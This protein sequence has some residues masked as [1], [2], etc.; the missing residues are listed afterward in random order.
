LAVSAFYAVGNV[1]LHGWILDVGSIFLP[2]P[3][4]TLSL[5]FWGLLGGIA[6]ASFAVALV[7]FARREGGPRGLAWLG[8]GGDPLWLGAGVALALA[9]PLL[10]RR[11]VL[12]GAPLSDDETAYRFMAQLLASGRIRVLS[13]PMKTFFDNQFM[14][15]DGH[16][17][18]Q[19]FLGWPALLAPGVWLRVPGAMNALYSALTVPALFLSLRRLSGSRWARLGLLLFLSAPMLQI[20]AATELSHTSCLFALAW[21]AWLTLR[22][23]DSEAPVWS[24]AGVALAFSAAFFNRP[25]AALGVGGPLL[26][27]WALGAFRLPAQRRRAALLAFA[28]PA[29]AMAALFLAANRIQTGSA[30]KVAYQRALE[31]AHETGTRFTTRGRAQGVISTDMVYRGAGYPL[32]NLAIALLR[33]NVEFLG[34]SGAWLIACC[35]GGRRWARLAWAC[36]ACFFAV[37]LLLYSTGIDTFGPLHYFETALPL[38]VLIV[39]AVE[40]VSRWLLDCEA[41]PARVPA[42]S[43][44]YPVALVLG[45]VFSALLGYW[46]VRLALLSRLAENINMPRD[47]AIAAHLD[48]A[49][50]FVHRPYA[51]PCR[52]WPAQH[53][54][55]FRP[56]NDPDLRNP[57][58]WVN[59]LTVEEDRQLMSTLPG[60]KGYLL[61]WRPDCRVRF[62]PLE[63]IPPGVEPF[64]ETPAAPEPS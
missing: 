56:N 19:Y 1:H 59:H 62:A 63:E 13:P 38:L 20:A 5:L 24:H 53:F 17:Y 55:F 34:W 3:V 16:F 6:A 4:V 25:T 7:G 28:A 9:I 45:L 14:I 22:S 64:A 51:P 40:R 37:H 35:A 57:V 36:L 50:V 41:A 26:V 48:Q 61:L 32:A 33:L 39:L 46:P 15:N 43:S 42:G 60:R 47:A 11:F 58:L 8:R 2:N 27:W 52:S 10:I 44:L 12:D 23:R 49:V 21:L 31:Y 30:F 18:A 29:M 54:V